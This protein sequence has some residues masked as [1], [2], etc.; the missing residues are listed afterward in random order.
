MHPSIKKLHTFSIRRKLLIGNI[1][2]IVLVMLLSTMLNLNI[3]TRMLEDSVETNLR[4]MAFSLAKNNMVISALEENSPSGELNAF[5]DA[6]VVE[7]NSIDVIT[8]ADMTGKRIYH[9]DKELIGKYFVG[10]DEIE[11][12]TGKNYASRATGTRGFQFRYFYPIYNQGGKQL[13]FVMAST[14]MSNF[15]NLKQN[16]IV[17]SLK[18]GMIVLAVGI[19]ISAVLGINIKDSLLG[20]EPERI[21]A[22]LI[23]REEIFDSLDEGL[24][25]IDPN[26]EVVLANRAARTFLN[27]SGREMEGKNINELAPQLQLNQPIQT[28]KSTYRQNITLGS[29]DIVVDTMPI[30]RDGRILG[31]VAV[32][33]NRTELQKMAE[34]LTGVN[35]YVEALQAYSHEYMNRLH[36]ILGLLQIKAYDEATKYIMDISEIQG[37]VSNTIV[38]RIENRMLA[39]LILG[40]ISRAHEY[41]IDFNLAPTSYV[42]VHSKFLSSYSLVTIVGNLIENA[43]DAINALERDD[44]PRE[45]TLGVVEKEDS[46]LITL[47]DTGIG[48]SEETVSKILQESYSTKG[49]HRGTGMALIRQLVNDRG[50]HISIESEEGNGTCMSVI[51]EKKRGSGKED[52]S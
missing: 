32:L 27:I 29:V 28:G 25:A 21:A 17:S 12:Y 3:A 22:L 18:L 45:I 10:G 2:C 31:A 52:V 44:T 15:T 39:A 7:K 6:I 51:I 35:H 37:I 36:V 4:N 43:I 1:F 14:L 38:G 49:I 41:N 5:L 48:M 26:G 46:L 19:T 33:R 16:I 40:K 50:G 13:G 9:V 24:M 23:Q 34:Q 30:I 8:V 11:A 42:P 20:Y 47:D